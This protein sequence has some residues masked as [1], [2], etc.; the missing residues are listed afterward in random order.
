V[1]KKGFF[2]CYLKKY[3]CFFDHFYRM[4]M[5]RRYGYQFIDSVE[6]NLNTCILCWY[7]HLYPYK[8]KKNDFEVFPYRP[9]GPFFLR[10][11][12]R[13]PK[14]FCMYPFR[15][16]K[17]KCPKFSISASLWYGRLLCHVY[18][19]KKHPN[20]KYFIKKPSPH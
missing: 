20:V 1:I 5:D 14:T 11:P 15:Y 10:T 6:L 13:P 2:Y 18:K 9:Y 4:S 12:L 7:K 3:S 17:C 19:H 16:S 8:I